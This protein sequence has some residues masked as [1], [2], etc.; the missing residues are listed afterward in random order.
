MQHHLTGSLGLK[1]PGFVF[2][3]QFHLLSEAVECIQHL[4]T[5]TDKHLPYSDKN[6]FL[7]TSS[8]KQGMKY[9]K[10]NYLLTAV[11][12]VKD[13]TGISALQ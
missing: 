5:R 7:P 12:T 8:L 3:F 10:N 4:N 6:S 11:G 13:V 2:Y 9:C 1:F